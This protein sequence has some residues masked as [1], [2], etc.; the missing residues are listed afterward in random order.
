MKNIVAILGAISLGSCMAGPPQPANANAQA[1][2]AGLLAG[3]TATGTTSCIPE[4][5]ATTAPVIAPTAIAFEVNPTLVYVSDVRGTGCEGLGDFNHTLV[6]TSRGSTGLCSGDIV[7]I[8]D[9]S[10]GVHVG[11]CSIGPLVAYRQQ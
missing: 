7:S 1:R 5:R 11:N 10:T 4:Y 9:S 2:L 3:K 8:V 6:T